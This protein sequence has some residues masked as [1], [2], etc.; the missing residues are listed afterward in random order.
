[1]TTVSRKISLNII[2]LDPV[3]KPRDDNRIKLCRKIITKSL[4][5]V[6]RLAKLNLKKLTML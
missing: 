1:M 3:V 6:K 2:K 5:L 4:V